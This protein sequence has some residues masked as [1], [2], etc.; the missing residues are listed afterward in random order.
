MRGDPSARTEPGDGRPAAGWYP[1]YAAPSGHERY[2]DGRDWTELTRAAPGVDGPSDLHPS[3]GTERLRSL[4]SRASLRGAVVVV[5]VLAVLATVVVLAERDSRD[6]D[7]EG[8]AQTV[9]QPAGASDPAGGDEESDGPSGGGAVDGRTF[10]VATVADPLTLL[11]TNDVAVRL[12]GVEDPVGACAPLALE[13]MQELVQGRDV[14]LVRRGP[15]RDDAGQ[16]LRYVERDGVDVGMRLIQ[17]GLAA[18]SAEPHAR[19]AIYRRV[20]AR[21]TPGC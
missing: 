14:T 17:R 1:D 16:L 4:A 19:G 20:A 9:S 15:D 2:W 21:A 6:P 13:A 10:E 3:Q 18:A 5:V 12:V 7:G 8:A 11:L